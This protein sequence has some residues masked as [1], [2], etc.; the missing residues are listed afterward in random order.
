VIADPVVDNALEVVAGKVISHG[1]DKDAVYKAAIGQGYRDLA[2]RYLGEPP[3][4]L[5]LVL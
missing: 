1:R 2:F 3:E 5:I 4:G